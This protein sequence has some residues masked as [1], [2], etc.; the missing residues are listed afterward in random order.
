MKHQQAF[1]VCTGKQI[2]VFI[3]VL[4]NL[5]LRGYNFPHKLTIS[6]CKVEQFCIFHYVYYFTISMFSNGFVRNGWSIN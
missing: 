5:L 6:H 1:D 4:F 2:G 3:R